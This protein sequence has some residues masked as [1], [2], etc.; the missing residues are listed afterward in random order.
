MRVLRMVENHACLLRCVAVGGYPPPSVQ[1]HVG[2]RDVSTEFNVSNSLS[3]VSGVRGMRHIS[4]QSE[5]WNNEFE[6]AADDDDTVIKCVAAVPGLKPTVQLTQLHV[7]CKFR[8]LAVF[9]LP[10]YRR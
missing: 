5:R 6:V 2:R 4:I 10:S 1:V 3:L 7:D 9:S 8:R